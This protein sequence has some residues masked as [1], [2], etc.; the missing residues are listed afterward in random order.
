MADG[1]AAAAVGTAAKSRASPRGGDDDDDDGGGGGGGDGGGSPNGAATMPSFL[2]SGP[3]GVR[4]P[5]IGF[6][7]GTAW[8]EGSN[9]DQFANALTAALDAGFRSLDSAEMYG[10]EKAEGAVVGKWLERTGTKR[11][12]VIVTSKLLASIESEVRTAVL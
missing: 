5:A 10:N 8:F 7:T 11:K 1:T 4:L 2:L 12:E 6:G 9:A 3:G